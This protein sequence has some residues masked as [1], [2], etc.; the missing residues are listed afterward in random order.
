MINHPASTGGAYR[1]RH[2]RWMRDAMDAL[3]SPGERDRCGWQSRV[4]LIPRRWDQVLGDD[5]ETTVATKPGTPRERGI[6]HKTIVQ[7]M[8]VVRRACGDCRLLFL[9]GG[10]WVRPAPGIPC[11]LPFEGDGKAKLGQIHA[12]R[13]LLLIPPSL[14]RSH[15]SPRVALAD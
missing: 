6:S 3:V 15:A 10:P 8:P 4:V 13:T 14:P 5:P 9:L 11:A 1:D 2:G 12:A 7:G